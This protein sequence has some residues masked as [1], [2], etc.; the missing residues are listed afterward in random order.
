MSS[1]LVYTESRRDRLEQQ[2]SA[3]ANKLAI[4]ERRNYGMRVI[5]Y[6]MVKEGLLSIYCEDMRTQ[7][8]AEYPVEPENAYEWFDHA[9]AH[10][11]ANLTPYYQNQNMES[12]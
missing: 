12:V 6:L 10:Q 7:S 5:L 11:D 9:F 4:E 8:S 2:L 1:E 3:E